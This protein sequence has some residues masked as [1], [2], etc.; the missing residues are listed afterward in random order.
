MKI[1]IH[2]DVQDGEYGVWG[3]ETFYA[4]GLEQLGHQVVKYE[5]LAGNVGASLSLLRSLEADV[6]IVEVC[7]AYKKGL[8]TTAFYRGLNAL[9]EAGQKVLVLVLDD[10]RVFQR[11]KD[12][13]ASV[14]RGFIWNHT[15]QLAGQYV[16][17]TYVAPLTVEHFVYDGLSGGVYS[18]LPLSKDIDMVFN[19]SLYSFRQDFLGHLL[20]KLPEWLNLKILSPSLIKNRYQDGHAKYLPHDVL[21]SY[22]KRAKILLSFGIYADDVAHYSEKDLSDLKWVPNR[23]WSYPC[24]FF[25]MLASG[26][27]VLADWRREADHCGVPDKEFVLYESIDDLVQKIQYYLEHEQERE[28]IAQ[29]GQQRFLQDHK[30]TKRLTDVLDACVSFY[31]K[32]KL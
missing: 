8:N 27:L 11:L 16:G 28:Q 18:A 12:T 14:Y 23:C 24:R 29:A 17:H 15:S 19:G 21:S 1:A 13:V 6:T 4:W 25:S 20:P 10:P 7:A 32:G 30:V 9:N 22:Y 3:T 5:H 31:K 26:S 2:K